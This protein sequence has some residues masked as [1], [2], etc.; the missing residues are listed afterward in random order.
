[1]NTIKR[2]LSTGLAA[3]ALT[4]GCA[5]KSNDAQ[6][7]TSFRSVVS[8]QEF[9]VIYQRAPP[10]WQLFP[11]ALEHYSTLGAPKNNN[12][13][14]R[15]GFIDACENGSLKLF[16]PDEFWQS[17]E[18]YQRLGAELSQQIAHPQLPAEMPR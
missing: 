3:I 2:A 10:T 4:V 1:M 11:V 7:P 5:K 15:S 16:R 9:D 18:E 12:C 13:L 14:Y 8:G 17:F 6:Y